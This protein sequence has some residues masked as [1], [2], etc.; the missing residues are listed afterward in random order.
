M[1]WSHVKSFI[2]K[3]IHLLKKTDGQI[4]CISELLIKRLNTKMKTIFFQLMQA[5]ALIFL[6]KSFHLSDFDYSINQSK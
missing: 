5:F 2:F 1:H 6:T 3:I 4:W